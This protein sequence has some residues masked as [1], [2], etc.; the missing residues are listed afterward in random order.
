MLLVVFYV[1]QLAVGANKARSS[2]TWSSPGH[3]SLIV[4]SRYAAGRPAERAGPGGKSRVVC[5]RGTSHHRCGFNISVSVNLCTLVDRK[6][7][8]GLVL[9]TV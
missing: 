8:G 5:H 3:L 2:R 4:F 9:E 6:W 7:D 1:I